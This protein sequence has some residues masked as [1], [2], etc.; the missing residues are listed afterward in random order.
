MKARCSSH[1]C[2]PSPLGWTSAGRSFSASTTSSSSVRPASPASRLR[3]HSCASS[4][5]RRTVLGS[6]PRWVAMRFL[7]TPLSHSRRTSLTSSIV[8]SRYAIGPPGPRPGSP[9]RSE[10]RGHTRGGN[11]PEKLLRTEGGMLLKNPRRKGGM[12]LKKSGRQGP[13]PLKTDTLACEVAA[14]GTR[15]N[16]L[17]DLGPE[18]LAKFRRL[19][20]MTDEEVSSTVYELL[21]GTAGV[22]KGLALEMLRPDGSRRTPDYRVHNIGV[23]ASVECKRRLG[24]SQYERKEAEAVQMLYQSIREPLADPRWT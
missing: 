8:T 13:Y 17:R 23:P 9:K 14:L 12:L 22:R 20:T 19:P 11:A 21:V 18:A 2:H 24:L 1:R 16:E 4:T 5:C 10:S 3:P 6:R 15:L 7:G